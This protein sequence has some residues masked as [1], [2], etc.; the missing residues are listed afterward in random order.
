MSAPG[1]SSSAPSA[2]PLGIENTIV[3][4]TIFLVIITGAQ[5][6]INHLGIRLTAKLTDFSGYLIFG[7][8]ILIAIVCLLAA[9]TWDFGRLFT[10]TNYSGEAGGSVWPAVSNWPGSSCSACC[11]RSTRS[12]AT[13]PR[14][15]RPRKP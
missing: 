15:I 8:S 7:G 13:T 9:E 10:F 14:R 11:C 1:L 3:T 2:R 12:P 5:A 4:Q 6:L